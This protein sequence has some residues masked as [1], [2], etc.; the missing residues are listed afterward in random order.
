[1]TARLRNSKPYSS[2]YWRG[3]YYEVYLDDDDEDD[4]DDYDFAD[5]QSFLDDEA[6]PP[7]R[8]DHK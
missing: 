4:D 6:L 7:T 5:E 3:K 8:L 2:G 1:M